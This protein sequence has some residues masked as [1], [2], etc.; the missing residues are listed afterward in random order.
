MKATSLTKEKIEAVDTEALKDNLNVP[1]EEIEN[2][3]N[4]S[5][6]REIQ[7]NPETP[8]TANTDHQSSP[9]EVDTE[10]PGKETKNTD[11]RQKSEEVLEEIHEETT[12]KPKSHTKNSEEYQKSELKDVEQP[13]IDSEKVKESQGE[14]KFI[15]KLPEK[16]VVGS[17]SRRHFVEESAPAQA[18]D[19][20]P[21]QTAQSGGWGCRLG[22]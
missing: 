18:K 11:N 20:T 7:E 12:D 17:K 2:T 9:E 1:D 4:Q 19:D 6:P 3:D 14:S 15:G 10:T 8:E 21:K 13:E 5:S 22:G 16:K